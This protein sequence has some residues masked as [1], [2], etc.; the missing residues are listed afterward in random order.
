[1]RVSIYLYDL[2]DTCLM[3]NSPIEYP[4]LDSHATC[5]LAIRSPPTL[6]ASST[7]AQ[8]LKRR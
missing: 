3:T 4:H 5:R 7:L 6:L 8:T 1:V 2:I